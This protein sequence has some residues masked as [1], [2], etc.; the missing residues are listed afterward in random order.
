MRLQGLQRIYTFSDFD[1]RR[2]T[3]RPQGFV[4]QQQG[5]L[6]VLDCQ[7]DIITSTL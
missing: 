1:L 6:L 5:P 2:S 7:P 3:P 4:Q